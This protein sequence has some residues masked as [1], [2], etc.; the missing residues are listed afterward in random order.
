[1]LVFDKDA[2]FVPEPGAGLLA[3]GLLALQR[4]RKG[5]RL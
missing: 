3:L 5:R 2:I 4:C 1:V